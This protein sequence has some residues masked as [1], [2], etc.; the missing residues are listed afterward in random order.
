MFGELAAEAA[1]KYLEEGPHG[2]FRFRAPFARYDAAFL[3]AFFKVRLTS[4]SKRLVCCEGSWCV[5]AFGQ[6]AKP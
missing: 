2:R 6:V 3:Q 5:K 1:S 4:T